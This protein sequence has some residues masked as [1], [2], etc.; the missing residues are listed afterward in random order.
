VRASP[1]SRGCEGSAGDYSGQGRERT[2]PVCLI[3][4]E[5]FDLLF[6]QCALA[7]AGSWS[8]SFSFLVWAAANRLSAASH[9]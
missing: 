9:P 3:M 5:L 6:A 1:E 7:V 8:D 4:T 2:A